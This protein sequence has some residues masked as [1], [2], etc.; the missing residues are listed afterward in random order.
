MSKNRKRPSAWETPMQYRDGRPLCRWCGGEVP[1]PRRTFCSPA[2]AD[3]WQIRS[4][5]GYARQKVW[6][7]DHGVCSQC[8]KPSPSDW[9]CHHVVAVAEGG[10]ECGLDGLVTLCRSCHLIETAALA[11][12]RA[13]VPDGT[14]LAFE[15]VELAP[16]SV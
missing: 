8:G 10:G 7:R 11:K 1:K 5:P 6:E 16:T 3:E 12:R 9:E 13:G 2:C 14:Q 15:D 4:N